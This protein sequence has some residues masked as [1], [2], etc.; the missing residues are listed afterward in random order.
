M[1]IARTKSSSFE[2]EVK[3]LEQQEKDIEDA[4]EEIWERL[5]EQPND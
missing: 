3:T 2:E 5:N 1:L 4:F